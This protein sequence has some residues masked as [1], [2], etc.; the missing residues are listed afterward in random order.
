M[1]RA[2]KNKHF[3]LF[4]SESSRNALLKLL[5]L[6]LQRF[7]VL[8]PYVYVSELEVEKAHDKCDK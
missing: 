6:I 5:Y 1:E 8:T 2:L 4:L 3:F 7:S